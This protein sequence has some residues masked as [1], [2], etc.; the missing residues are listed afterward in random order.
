M[1]PSILSFPL[2]RLETHPMGNAIIAYVDNKFAIAAF[3][4]YECKW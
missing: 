2:D 4:Y 1:F 3:Q